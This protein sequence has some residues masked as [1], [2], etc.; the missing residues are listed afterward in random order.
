MNSYII[1]GLRDVHLDLGDNFF[2]LIDLADLERVQSLGI[3]FRA[4]DLNGKYYACAEKRIDG[5][6][7]L[8]LLHR[9]IMNTPSDLEC[10]HL[11]GNGL[12]NRSHNLRNITQQ[13]NK[14]NKRVYKNS[15]SG[16]RG[17]MYV[18]EKDRWRVRLT[19]DGKKV[20][21][22]YFDTLE[23]AEEQAIK[24]RKKLLPFSTI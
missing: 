6:R 1:D 12:D 8:I 13:Q 7:T 9:F 23:E 18:E 22:G 14:Q 19:V 21:I 17:V 20:H 16:V 5:K 15:K 10:D 11:N 2:A 4:R 24:A 3:T